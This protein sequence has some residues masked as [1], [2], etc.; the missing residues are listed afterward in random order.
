MANFSQ[1]EA[2]WLSGS[3]LAGFSRIAVLL[4]GFLKVDILIDAVTPYGEDWARTILGSLCCVCIEDT[5]LTVSLS[6]H[7][8]KLISA[9]VKRN[10]KNFNGGGGGG[11]LVRN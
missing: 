10:F 8:C 3:N 1:N 4:L 5:T 7:E 6:T 11:V 2:R 9:N